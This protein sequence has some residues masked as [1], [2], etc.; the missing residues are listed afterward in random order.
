MAA[1]RDPSANGAP[2]SSS[3]P[4]EYM[5]CRTIP[6][7]PEVMTYG[8][9]AS[10]TATPRNPSSTKSSPQS[11]TK[12][13]R[14]SP[15]S[16]YS[17][18]ASARSRQK[19]APL[20]ACS[21]AWPPS[22]SATDSRRATSSGL[23]ARKKHESAAQHARNAARNRRP[24][25]KP[26]VSAAPKSSAAM[27]HARKTRPPRVPSARD[28][29]EGGP[30]ASGSALPYTCAMQLLVRFLA[31]TFASSWLLA[32][33]QF[34]LARAGAPPAALLAAKVAYMFGP[35]LGARIAL[36]AGFADAAGVKWRPNA[37]WLGA[38]LLPPALALA[39]HGASALVPGVEASYGAE[40]LLERL[41][42]LVAPEDV[43]KAR[44]QL[45]KYPPG[46]L[47]PLVLF[48]ALLAGPTVNAVAAFGEEVGWRGALHHMLGAS[49]PG[50]FWRASAITGIVWGIWHAPLILQGHN[51]PRH[52]KWGVP[53]MVAFCTLLSPLLAHFR[54]AGGSVLAPALFH[55]SLNASAGLSVMFLKGGSDLVVGLTGAAGLAVL[56]AADVCLW[57]IRGFRR[58]PLA[59][60]LRVPKMRVYPVVT[61]C[62]EGPVVVLSSSAEAAALRAKDHFGLP[63]DAFG[64][65]SF[66]VRG[67]P[68]KVYVVGSWERGCC[69]G[70]LGVYADEGTAN[71]AAARPPTLAQILANQV[72]KVVRECPVFATVAEYEAF[73]TDEDEKGRAEYEARVAERKKKQKAARDAV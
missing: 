44:E 59:S 5:G 49:E 35:L 26:V 47:L 70:L 38:W 21:A 56:A 43:E 54:I 4:P 16:L 52:P 48:Q 6:Y 32:L 7:G 57:W 41:E 12:R 51:Y 61:I 30:D 14:R 50:R 18:P 13:G 45:A 1:Q 63:P 37:A 15:S 55:G 36:G 71:A 31:P 72:E 67:S 40:G 27:A 28:A 23:N 22:G 46:R 42:G 62:G 8:L 29:G 39:A 65:T 73:Q 3:A 53:M 19:S 68:D 25:G 60:H 34:R 11:C 20:A 24:G 33:V 2:S 66:E 17:K 9:V 64:P 58:T 69:A 10:A